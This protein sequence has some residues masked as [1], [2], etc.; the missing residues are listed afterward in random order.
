MLRRA[1]THPPVAAPPPAATLPASP[2]QLLERRAQLLR[3]RQ[4]RSRHRGVQGLRRQVSRLPRRARGAVLHRDVVVPERELQGRARVVRDRRRQ[5]QEREPAPYAGT[6]R[7]LLRGSVLRA[8]E[9]ARGR[10]SHVPA[11][12]H[13]V[14]RQQRRRPRH[15]SSAPPRQKLIKNEG[16]FTE[17]FTKDWGMGSVNKAILVGNLGRDAEM[18]FTAGGTPV[19]TVQHRDDGKVHRPRGTEARRHA[20]APHRHLGQDGGVAARVPHQG[21]ADLRRRPDPDA[22]VGRQGR[23]R[24]KTTEIRADKI[25]LLG[26][27]G[28]GEMR[29]AGGTR[30]GRER[31]ADPGGD[32]A[33][34]D[35]GARRRAQRRRHSVLEPTRSSGSSRIEVGDQDTR[36]HLNLPI[37]VEPADHRSIGFLSFPPVAIL[38]PDDVVQLRRRASRM[39][40]S[41]IAVMR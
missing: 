33:P 4:V 20:V 40:A 24:Q 26:G 17:T 29:A 9:P 39:S 18:R 35:M 21:Q 11:G 27:G 5:V 13:A 41:S 23:R 10:D 19:A 6:G 15:T 37:L 22:R 30:P 25:V 2:L 1:R 3:H 32:A 36:D 12:T 7:V 34:A 8:A 28:G 14:P 16:L 38:E 31:F